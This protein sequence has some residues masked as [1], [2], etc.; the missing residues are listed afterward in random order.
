MLLLSHVSVK[1]KTQHSF[2]VC[3]VFQRVYIVQFVVRGSYFGE[4]NERYSQLVWVSRK[5]GPDTVHF[6][7]FCLLSHRLRQF[8]CGCAAVVGVDF[9][10]VC[11]SRP[12]LCNSLACARF[13]LHIIVFLIAKKSP[14]AVCVLLFP[15]KPLYMSFESSWT[16]LVVQTLL[17]IGNDRYF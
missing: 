7:R 11:R 1:T 17:N 9:R 12:R 14:T 16:G 3:W 5:P 6:P 13:N 15:N 2:T 8:L 4:Y 10:A